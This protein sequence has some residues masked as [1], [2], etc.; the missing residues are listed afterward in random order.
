MK[1]T[2]VQL[3]PYDD[4]ISARD[5]MSWCR[6]GR[7]LLVFPEA[8]R[9]LDQKLDLVLLQRYSQTLGAQMAIVSDNFE[10]QANAKE[11]GIPVFPSASKAQKTPWRRLRIRRR[12]FEKKEIPSRLSE[13]QGKSENRI[14]AIWQSPRLRLSAF[15]ISLL[16]VALLAWFFIPSAQ[17]AMPAVRKEQ[18]LT[19]AIRA[20]PSLVGINP[21]GAIPA[22]VDT[23]IVES[24]GQAASSGTILVPDQPAQATIKFTNL[25]PL[26]VLV[27][28]GTVLLTFQNQSIRYKVMQTVTVPAGAGQTASGTVQAVNAGSGGNAAAGTINA[29]E[30]S[31]G[32]RLVATNP[33]AAQGGTDRTA[34]SP[35]Q[36]DY[37]NLQ[38][39]VESQLNQAALQ[40]IQT[41]LT[42]GEKIIPGSLIMVSIIQ[43]TREP[44]VGQPSDMLKLSLR[45]EFR[46]W[47]IQ[48]KDVQQ[49]AEIALDANLDPGTAGV[50]GSLK[51]ED[52]DQPQIQND[53]AHWKIKASRQTEQVWDR[54][55]VISLIV[56]LRPEDAR[57]KLK[58]ALG[59]AEYP[60]I[61]VTPSWWPFLPSLPF[62]IQVKSQ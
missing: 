53:G 3:E 2:V 38:K 40:E 61:T 19:L 45:A 35:T 43:Q 34:H 14:A 16:A 21:S 62:R 28:Q 1:T 5:K 18:T 15:F 51:C 11:V 39:T 6:S 55:Q 33:E 25:T 31:L 57:Q 54:E 60:Q 36:A 48:N 8:V 41:K 30:G 17:V 22:T 37:A 12:L 32:L 10:I 46:A 49:V 7:I 50:G 9:I 26:A 13:A 56:G 47:H 58:N 44:A 52:L 29:F 59:F 4:N 20:S 27:P 24:Q 23:L 42:S